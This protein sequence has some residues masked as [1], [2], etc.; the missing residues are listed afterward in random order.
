MAFIL[1]EVFFL[2]I[3]IFELSSGSPAQ[4]AAVGELIVGRF[5]LY[6]WVIVVFIGLVIPA[7]IEGRELRGYQIPSYVVPALILIGSFSFRV[8][9]VEAGQL[10]LI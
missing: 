5:A 3:Y 7:I 1:F 9:M 2:I 8:L 4:V 6:F 10:L